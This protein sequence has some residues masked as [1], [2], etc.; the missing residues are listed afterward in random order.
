MENSPSAEIN[1]E[2]TIFLKSLWN[3]SNG[4]IQTFKQKLEE[5]FDTTMER[6]SGWYKRYTQFILF[7]IGLLIAVAFNV[8]SIIIAQ[9]LS[10]D[11]KLREQVIQSANAYME[12]EQEFAAGLSLAE[13]GSA[14]EE[15]IS[16]ELD[17][18]RERSQ[19]LQRQANELLQKD[20]GNINQIMGL[21]YG[22]NHTRLAHIFFFAYSDASLMNFFGWV[23]TALA[24]SLGAPFWF[25]LLKKIMKVRGTGTKLETPAENTINKTSKPQPITVQVNNQSTE[26]AV[27]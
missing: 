8:D 4:N 2:T 27:G 13:P 25:D 3:E 14:E 19:E 15:V 12:R 1:P 7:I 5:W 18:L 6:A 17:A 10:S 23:I 22:C 26:E 9:K 16:S 11:P 21:G 20:I 24:I